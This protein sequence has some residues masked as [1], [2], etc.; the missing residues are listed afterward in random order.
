MKM[1][2][3]IP[4][5]LV[6]TG[7]M[8]AAPFALAQQGK[9]RQLMPA[10]GSGMSSGDMSGSKADGTM[11][12]TGTMPMGAQSPY[13]PK[14][15]KKGDRLPAEFRDRQYV[16]EKDKYKEYGLPAPMKGNHW[17]GVGADYYE[18]SGNGTIRGVGAGGS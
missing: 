1:K 15:W 11:G 7:I 18:V 3:L 5:V 8:M 12:Q 6:A 2:T 17:V 13:S 10:A 14:V 9:M 16:I 4:T